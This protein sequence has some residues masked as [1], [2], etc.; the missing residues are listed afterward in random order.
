MNKAMTGFSCNK[1]PEPVCTA[2]LIR[3][4]V[5][6]DSTFALGS[7]IAS[8]PL[9][10]LTSLA[11]A[12]F[13]GAHALGVYTLAVYLVT[14]LSVVSRLGL[15][16]AMVRFGA[17]LKAAGQGGVI[18]ALFWQGLALVLSL[19]LIAALWLYLTQNWLV[20]VFHAPDLPQVLNLMFLALPL[21]GAAA[22]C[23]ETLRSLGAARWVVAQQDLLTPFGLLAGVGCLAWQGQNSS[24]PAAGLALA[25]LANLVLGLGFLT[26]LLRRK[27][28]KL[29]ATLRGARLGEFLRYS[30][31]LYLSTLLM[32][33]FSVADTLVL[34][35]STAPEKVAYYEA[36]SRIALLV[37]VPL[38]AVNA[39]IP[40][41]FAH[42]HQEERFRELEELTRA[43]TR[44]MYCV[45]L[46]LA[47]LLAA[48]APDIL[49][50]FGTGFVEARWALR[51][52]AMAQLFNVASGSVGFLLAMTGNQYMLIKSLAV[53]G[54][55]GLPLMVLG[56][57]GF[58]LFGLALAKGFWLVG[59]NALM[60]IGVWRSLRFKIFAS[61][62]GWAN[63]SAAAGLG[64]LCLA[65]PY[66]GSWTAGSM[67]VLTYL[68][69]MI[70]PLYQEFN[71]ILSQARSEVL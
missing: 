11:L 37:S 36:A 22:F 45:S 28:K 19:S 55:L 39:I 8:L 56:A 35:L 51:I 16:T 2:A 41:I 46:P 52:L 66:V 34:G 5:A 50:L 17:G 64:L 49:E 10:C 6:I 26:V 53:G 12:R 43:S 13:W 1:G 71:D 60:S 31:P 68:T 69:L 30:W 44:W 62:L 58:G 15:D 42:M 48:L 21:I 7:K 63:A 27:L 32:L 23:G 24:R 47:L 25:Y 29:Q 57:F 38:M 18:K 20:S 9:G 4:R 59:M 33:A 3:Y 67:A 40:P 65:R 14:A 54:A 70:R 61:G